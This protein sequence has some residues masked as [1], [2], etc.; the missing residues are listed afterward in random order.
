MKK[1]QWNDNNFDGVFEEFIAVVMASCES[2]L[3]YIHLDFL[4]HKWSKYQPNKD[5]GNDESI[6]L[7][8][9]FVI[10]Q[11]SLVEVHDLQQDERFSQQNILLA[12]KAVRHLIGIPLI[13]NDGCVVG[14]IC[15]FDIKPKRLD[16]HQNIMLK[17]LARDIVLHVEVLRKE[18]LLSE[19]TQLRQTLNKDLDEFTYIASHDLASPLNAIKNLVSWIEEDAEQGITRDNPKYFKMIKNSIERMHRLLK[20]LA[21]YARISRC[22]TSPEH[23]GLKT[24]ISECCELL[25]NSHH[26]DVQ[27]SGSDIE[28][29]KPPLMIVLQHLISNAIKH[30]H[31]GSGII[32]INCLSHTDHYQLL[33][34][35]DGPGIPPE[36]KDKIFQPFQTLK[37]KDELESSG[38]GLAIVKKTLALYAGSIVIEDQQGG[39]AVFT[40]IWPKSAGNKN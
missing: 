6:A 13:T 33:V 25:D 28:L 11:K 24:I 18:Q 40:I 39:G 26:F 2:S 36:F 5:K 14:A 8:S 16:S 15:L 30:H 23:I 22:D 27:V 20:G 7:V 21:S 19:L 29:P 4:T 3:C 1:N 34:S 17:L 38:L 37:P 32:K 31:K 10:A 12:N 9:D 35:D